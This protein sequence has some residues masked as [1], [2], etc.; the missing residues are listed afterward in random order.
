MIGMDVQVGGSD[1]LA[2]FQWQKAA[3]KWADTVGPIGRTAL[4]ARA[5][6]GKGDRAGRFADSIRYQRKTGRTVEVMYTANTPYARYVIEPTRPHTIV[7]RAA[8]YLH[9]VDSSG[10]DQFR[11]QV[12]HPGT[13]GNPFHLSTMRHYVP[14]AQAAYTRIMREALG[15]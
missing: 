13:P 4:K 9:W 12:R 1:A 8:R 7:A 14:V 2:R 6:R 11:K 3:V 15:G 10:R 5:P